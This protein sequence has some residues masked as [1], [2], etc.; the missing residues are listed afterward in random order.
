MKKNIN[1][2]IIALSFVVYN[3]YQAHAWILFDTS[4]PTSTARA[5][6]FN[7]LLPYQ[8]Q[9]RLARGFANASA[10]SSQVAT[11][12]GFQGYETFAITL[13][14][15]AAAQVPATTTN[16]SY[17]KHLAKKLYQQGDVY[18]GV[19]WNAWSLNAGVR[20]PGDIYLSGKFGKLIYSYHDFDFDGMHAGGMI[21]YQIIK[22]MAP[23]VKIVLWR[24]LSIGT[25]YLWQYNNTAYHY[26][27][28]PTTFS[29]VQPIV[30][31]PEMEITARTTSH[32]IPLELSTA[33]RLF[34]FLNIH[35]GGGVDFAWGSSRLKY[36]G[37]GVIAEGS[38]TGLYAVYG[39]QGGNGPKHYKFK[40]FCGPGLSIGPVIVDLPFTYYFRDGFNAGVTVGVVW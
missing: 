36:S 17:Y 14:T 31:R 10:Y 30:V 26:K 39:K 7:T 38:S 34:W 21:N 27:G 5:A 19:A 15:M 40:I 35:A 28:K 22:Q 18:V 11:Q 6:V 23:A 2:I 20:L 29:G 3:V 16:L 37:T 8:Y 13:G 1:I 32:V 9:P 33:V 25:G 24:G 12:R 4:L